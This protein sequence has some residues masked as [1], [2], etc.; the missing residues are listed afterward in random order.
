[1]LEHARLQGS[2]LLLGIVQV[3]YK[4]FVV[5][6]EVYLWV[7]ARQVVVGLRK[8]ILGHDELINLEKTHIFVEPEESRDAIFVFKLVLIV[9]A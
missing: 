7:V 4:T 6:C 3:V 1:M 9:R 8:T 5:L 2:V